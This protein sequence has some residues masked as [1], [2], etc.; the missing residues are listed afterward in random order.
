MRGRSST[1][2]SL[3][4]ANAVAPRSSCSRRAAKASQGGLM[5]SNMPMK[6]TK[7]CQLY[8][9]DCLAGAARPVVV[10]EGRRASPAVLSSTIT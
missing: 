1:T 6:L 2:N 7:A 5:L 8:C 9:G 3:V 4:A 10:N